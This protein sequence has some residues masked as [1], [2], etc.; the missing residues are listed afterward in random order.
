MTWVN[1]YIYDEIHTIIHSNEKCEITQLPSIVHDANAMDFWG[2]I[3]KAR[4]PSFAW[5]KRE[6][7]G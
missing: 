3:F 7:D 4:H 2:S 5:L 1:I 6:L